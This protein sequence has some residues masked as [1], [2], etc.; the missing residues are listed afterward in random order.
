MS[1]GTGL[2]ALVIDDDDAIRQLISKVLSAHGFETV[3][4]TDGLD[5]LMQMETACPD[6]IVS[7][8][9][10]P[11]LDGLSLLKAL[12]RQAATT[13]IPVIFISAKSEALDIADGMRAGAFYYLT[14]PFRRDDL[15]SRVREV[16]AKLSSV[17]SASRF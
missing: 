4:A 1:L 2:R 3:V 5:A 17:P 15:V 7:D 13:H 16:V 12:K 8:M 10:M 9:M 14:K 11:N 6:F